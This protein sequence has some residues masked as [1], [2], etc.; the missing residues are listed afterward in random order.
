MGVETALI[1]GS[2]AVAVAAAGAGTY[3]AVQ[4]SKNAAKAA[5]YNQ[6]I[7]EENM[8]IAAGQAAQNEDAQR[9]R[10]RF[11]L[12]KQR[13]AQAETGLEF[14]GSQLDIYEQSATE[15]ELD[16][17][18]VRY[19]GEL[20]RRGFAQDASMAAFEGGVARQQRQAAL[21]QG[22]VNTGSAMLSGYSSYRQYR[23]LTPR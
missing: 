7:A 20:E 12:A 5:K 10:A 21:I 8:D 2:M 14:S 6:E 13:A 16:S 15:A 4:S 18:T 3:V 9:R 23:G 11:F 1:I 22:G 17:L 19:Q